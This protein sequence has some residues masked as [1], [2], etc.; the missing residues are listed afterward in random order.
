MKKMT[1]DEFIKKLESRRNDIICEG[2]YCGSQSKIKFRCKKCGT[3]WFAKPSNILYGK[4]CP[5]CKNKKTHTEFLEE[6]KSI[7]YRRV[8]ER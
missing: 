5:G 2:I 8:C 1:H 4:G 7:N 6:M 3:T